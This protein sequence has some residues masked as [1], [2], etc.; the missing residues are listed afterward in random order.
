MTNS[1]DKLIRVLDYWLTTELLSQE[2]YPKVR[3]IKNGRNKSIKDKRDHLETF[4]T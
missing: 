4:L 3:S 2:P 1:N